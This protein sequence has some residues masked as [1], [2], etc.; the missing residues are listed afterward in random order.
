MR[1]EYI[2]DCEEAVESQAIR[3][4]HIVGDVIEENS[5]VG[6]KLVRPLEKQRPRGVVRRTYVMSASVLQ[7]ICGEYIGYSVSESF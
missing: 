7:T 5:V 2:I 3:V 4:G 6:R 1:E